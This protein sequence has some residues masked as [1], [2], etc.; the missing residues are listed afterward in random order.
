MRGNNGLYPLTG[1]LLMHDVMHDV[2]H[3]DSLTV[4]RTLPDES[5]QCWLRN[6]SRGGCESGTRRD[7][8]RT[9]CGLHRVGEETNFGER[10]AVCV[11]ST[12]THTGKEAVYAVDRLRNNEHR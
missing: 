5:V 1:S 10:F 7:R 12:D 3:G 8:H 9:Q 2:I 4:L 6:N 11:I